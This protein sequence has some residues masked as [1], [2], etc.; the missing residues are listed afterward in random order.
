MSDKKQAIISKILCE[1]EKNVSILVKDDFYSSVVNWSSGDIS[2]ICYF[3][4]RR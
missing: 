1:E 4:S 3:L 2:S